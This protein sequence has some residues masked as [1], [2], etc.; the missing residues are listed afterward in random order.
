MNLGYLLSNAANKYPDRSLSPGEVG[1][2]I[3]RGPNVMQGYHRNPEGTREALRDGWL[4]PE[5]WPQWTKRA[6]FI[7][8]I[9][10][11]I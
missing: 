8:W 11:K 10:R 5:I 9:A 7:L 3:C 1:E 2:L 6:S 4:L